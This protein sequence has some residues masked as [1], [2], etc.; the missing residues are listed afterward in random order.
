MCSW[1]YGFA[2]H[3]TNL[4]NHFA[5]SMDFRLVMGGLRP[6]GKETIGEIGDFLRHHWEEVNKRSGQPFSYEILKKSDFIYDTEPPCRAVVTMRE[7][8]PLLEFDFYKAV[9][10]EFY[11]KGSD[12]NDPNTYSRLAE[13]FGL[14]ENEFQ[15]AFIS[16]S[17]RE[18]MYED[19]NFSQNLGVRGFPTTVLESNGQLYML[20]NGYMEADLIKQSIDKILESI[21]AS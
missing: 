19:F 5:D 9:Q 20:A 21:K 1:C 10:E 18:K 13:T 12:T 2:P 3:I 8:N 15:V 6:G 4:K 14:D 17:I 11:Q 16:P 7:L